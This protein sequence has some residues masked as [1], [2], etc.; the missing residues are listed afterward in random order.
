VSIYSAPGPLRPLNGMYSPLVGGEAVP[1]D[2][3]VARI[4]SR[5]VGALIDFVV[6]LI[7]Y[8][9]LGGIVLATGLDPAAKRALIVLLLVVVFIGYPVVLEA[10]WGGRTLGKAAM[11]LR[12]ARDDGGPLRFRHA[13]M[14]GLIGVFVEKPGVTLGVAAVVSSLASVRGKRLGD[15]AAGT[16]VLQVRLPSTGVYVPP[17]PPPLAG[18]ASTLDLSR[19]PDGLALQSRQFLARASSLTF[20]ARE[21]LGASLVATVMSVVTP[22]PPPGTPGW[23]YL[24]AVL[25]ER[26]RRDELRQFPAAPTFA[27]PVYTPQPTYA[28]Q[29]MYAPPPAPAPETPASGFVLP[30]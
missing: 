22:P 4:G 14:R 30:S 9:F 12:A 25:A 1:V 24:A 7:G 10:T 15:L 20:D 21:R 28:P 29:P 23:A 26:R 11:G 6:Q 3:R 17:M 2:L 27:P 18:W 19:L 8:G 13:L 5:A 16:V